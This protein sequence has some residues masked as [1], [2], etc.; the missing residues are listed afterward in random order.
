MTRTAVDTRPGAVRA[1]GPPRWIATPV[2]RWRILAASAVVGVV[3]LVVAIAL[4]GAAT[5]TLLAD[6]GPLVRWGLPVVD[7]VV[8]LAAATTVGALVLCAVILPPPP[9]DAPPSGRPA[10]VRPVGAAWRLSQRIAAAAGVVW[11]LALAVQLVLTYARV[12]GRPIGGPTFGE[13]ISVFLG[14]IEL[15]RLL[16]TGL[17]LTALVALLAVAVGGTL[18]ATFAVVLAMV[19]L[20]PVASTGH[21]SGA[22]NHEVAVSSLWLHLAG[23]TLWIGGLA[24][25][26]AVAGALGR[27]L[28]PA[29]ARYSSLAIW[30]YALVAV[31]GVANAAIRLG[32]LDGLATP[33]GRLVLAKAA[34]TL[35]LGVAGWWHR[36]R[37]IPRLTQ[38]RTAA[39]WRLVV[40]EVLLAGGVMGLAVALSSTAPP[41]PDT[42]LVDVP[43]A[44]WITGYPVPDHGPSGLDWFT[45]WRPDLLVLIGV[46]SALVVVLTWYRRLRARGDHWPVLRVVSLAVGLLLIAWVSSGGPALYGHLL[47]SAHM[48]QHM[49]LVM[50]APIFLVLGAPVTLAVRALPARDDGSRGPRELLLGLVHSRWAGFFAN[51]VVAAV[52]I[53]GSMILFYYT[54]LLLLALTNHWVHLWMI[55]HF[56][57]AGYMFVN[58]LIGIDPGP[59]RP[60][61]PLRLLLL[62]ATMA[63]HAFFGLALMEGTQLLAAPWYG[64]LGLPWGVDALADQK[65]GGGFTWGFGEV[66]SLLLAIALGTAWIRDDDRTARRLDRKADRDGDADL[67]AYN[68]MLAARSGPGGGAPGEDVSDGATPDASAAHRATPDA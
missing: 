10:R 13:E 43:P 53:V 60:G 35:A 32:G 21:A 55:V 3:A 33:Y 5:P 29:A 52:N 39:F 44:E 20:A 57:L 17:V 46:V 65:L 1:D 22:A 8:E 50:L 58:V 49:V 11:T 19:A 41:V 28:R 14:Q 24:I 31:S 63:F 56:T 25:L 2:G 61:Y 7:L 18:S 47:F 6:P 27:D 38:G 62:F 37:T 68:A 30:A 54:P 40:G 16:L 59:R 15:G 45:T 64:A 66:P 26:V 12:S 36:R 34:A 9:P 4:T 51:P 42:P 48:V 23:V 67:A